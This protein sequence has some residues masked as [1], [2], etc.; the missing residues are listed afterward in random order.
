MDSAY[1]KPK[2]LT[3]ISNYLPGYKAGGILRSIV[4]TVDYLC[5]EFEFMIVTLDRDLKDIEPYPGVKVKQWQK[6][7]GALVYYLPPN[8][9]SL[10]NIVQL[11]N[12]TPHDVIYV[13]SFFDAVFTIKLLLARKIGWLSDKPMIMAPRGELSNASLKIKQ[14]KKKIFLL[15]AKLTGLYKNVTWQASSELEAQDIISIMNVET[16]TVHLSLDLPTKVKPEIGADQSDQAIS[17]NDGLKLIFLSRISREKNVDYALKVL[18]KAKAKIVFDIFGPTED[19]IYWNECQRLISQLPTNVTVNY[20]GCVTPDQV[21]VTFSHYDLF[22]FPTT[23]ENYGH[24]IAEALTAGTPVLISN[25]T[26][27]RNLEADGLGWVKELEDMDSFVAVIEKLAF[28]SDDDRLKRRSSIM[29][30]I[31]EKLLDP[32]VLEANRQLFIKQLNRRDVVK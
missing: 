4:N 13:N 19:E 5:D 17:V 24:V 27:W 20:L 26:P 1:K 8:A 29:I 16:E 10:R 12:E 23:G 31:M 15:V 6:V 2:I 25:T 30:K 32:S 18:C 14:I 21:V 7:G 11:S 9:C 28:S 22:F 3:F